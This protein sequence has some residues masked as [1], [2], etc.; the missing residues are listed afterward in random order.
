MRRV[1]LVLVVLVGCQIRAEAQVAAPVATLCTPEPP[2]PGVFRYAVDLA[3]KRTTGKRHY[4]AEDEVQ[5]VF[6]NKNIFLFDYNITVKEVPIPEPGLE[7]FFKVFNTSPTAALLAAVKTP[8]EKSGGTPPPKCINALMDLENLRTQYNDLKRQANEITLKFKELKDGADPEQRFR[9]EMTCPEMVQVASEI[10]SLVD[11]SLDESR[12]GSLGQKLKLFGEALK[13]Y[14]DAIEQ[15][16]AT[17]AAF[18]AMLTQAG[19]PP[20]IVQLGVEDFKTLLQSVDPNNDKGLRKVSA[21][22]ASAAQDARTASKKISDAL[23]DPLNFFEVDF[24]DFGLPNNIDIAVERKRKSDT[25]FAPYFNTT[26]FGGRQRFALAAGVAFTS[27]DMKT[28]KSVQGFELDSS[29]NL[30]MNNGQPNLTR[31]VGRDEDSSERVTPLIMLHTRVSE[32]NSWNSG[33]HLSFGFAGNLA[34]NGVNL[35]YLIG[36][37]ISFAEERFFITFGAYNGRTE[38]LQKGFF[39]GRALP[40]TITDVPVT[41]GRTWDWGFA[42]TYKFQ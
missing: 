14:Q 26:L 39:P 9:S 17:E 3:T 35:E 1:A 30:V 4:Q 25:K 19:C 42:A 28:Y 15:Q 27:L 12:A 32:G 22:F 37:S 33:Y 24:K 38:R 6:T 29:G 40:N 36:P 41:R 5:I 7:T 16:S 2:G 8:G 20:L 18:R 11:S 23:K 13:K 10:V 31:V 34:G 21:D